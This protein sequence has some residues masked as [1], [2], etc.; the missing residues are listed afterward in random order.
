MRERTEYC[1]EILPALFAPLILTNIHNTKANAPLWSITMGSTSSTH[2]YMF[3]T[4]RFT[5]RPH[6]R[7]VEEVEVVLDVAIAYHLLVRE[8]PRKAE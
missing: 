2:G 7:D 5:F 8:A 1:P 4:P 3:G 6:L